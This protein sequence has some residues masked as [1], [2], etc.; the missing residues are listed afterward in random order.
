MVISA[1]VLAIGKFIKSPGKGQFVE[2]QAQEIELLGE[3]VQA[4]FPIAKTELSLEY[5]RTI[6]HLRVRTQTISAVARI[7][8][9]LAFAVHNFFQELGYFYVHTP[10]IT[11]SD[12][13]GAGEMFQVSTLIP[14]SSLIKEI[15]ATKTG[16]LDYE[17]DFFK[18]P[19]YLTVS[20]KPLLLS[21][22]VH[23]RKRKFFFFY[24]KKK[25][26]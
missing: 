2:L 16:Q 10:V 19:A 21:F 14:K 15:P 7:R 12:C 26:N 23:C 20:G 11:A 22:I 18:K 3:C 25:D 24:T 8:N 9:S 13:E 5:L 6:P 1:S 17:Q 4:D